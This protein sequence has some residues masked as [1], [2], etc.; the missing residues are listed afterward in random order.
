MT[1]QARKTK[2]KEKAMRDKIKAYKNILSSH[3]G[4]KKVSISELISS[5]LIIQLAEEK[6]VNIGELVNE[7]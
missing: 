3:N 4:E 6:P 7:V 2:I 5:Y 1:Y